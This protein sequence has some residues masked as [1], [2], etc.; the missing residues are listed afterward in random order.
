MVLAP[1]F[2]ID[3][4]VLEVI[5]QFFYLQDLNLKLQHVNIVMQYYLASMGGLFEWTLLTTEGQTKGCKK[6]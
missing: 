2:I 5:I 1:T 4:V 6:N 3:A